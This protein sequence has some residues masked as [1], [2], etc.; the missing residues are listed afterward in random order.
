MQHLAMKVGPEEELLALRDRLRTNGVVVMGPIAHGMCR[1]LYSARPEGLTLHA[2]WSGPPLHPYR[3]IPHPA[4][5]AADLRPEASLG[6]YECAV[7][8]STPGSPHH[9]K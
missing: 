8:A 6:W 7:P 1:S 4:C 5:A 3:R 2:A 9:E